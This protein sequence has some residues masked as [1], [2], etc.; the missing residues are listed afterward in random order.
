VSRLAPLA[1]ALLLLAGASARAQ[2]RARCERVVLVVL[3][4]GVRS[5]E[6]LD[7]PDLMPTI[8]KI[9]AAG[10]SSRGWKAGGADHPAAVEAILTGRAPPEERAAGARPAAPTVLEYARRGL[11]LERDQAWFVSFSDED[12]ATARSEHADYGE[13]QAPMEALGEGPFDESL[14]TVLRV[15]G[16]PSPAKP[17]AT[18]LL[19]GLRAATARASAGRLP[20]RSAAEVSESERVEL[21]LLDDVDRRAVATGPNAKDARAL[22]AALAVLRV[23]RPRLLVVRLGQAD[24]AHDDLFAHWEVLKRNDAGIGRLRDEIAADPGLSG[25][26]LLVTAD[27]GRNTN[28]NAAGGYDHDDGGEDATTVAVV[29]EGPGLR[30]GASLASP[31][32]VRDLCPTVGRLLGFPT[33][34]AEGS[35]RTDLVPE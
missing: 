21:A 18:E 9:G 30:R 7:R 16:R 8:R 35:A 24:V 15:F 14:R 11:S 25:T 1:A 13:A 17:R 3:G 22:A 31:L 20:G 2:E 26:V 32:D 23:H 6:M 10:F 12:D 29:G 5:K 19:V 33:P 34:L 27:L 4:G 28:Q